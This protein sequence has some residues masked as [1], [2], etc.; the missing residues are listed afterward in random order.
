ML[1]YSI[2]LDRVWRGVGCGVSGFAFAK[3]S[4]VSQ[5]ALVGSVFFVF[6]KDKVFGKPKSFPNFMELVRGDT[7][8]VP[9]LSPGCDH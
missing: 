2:D 5:I 8:S 3:F 7:G 6:F 1:V 4:F 9:F